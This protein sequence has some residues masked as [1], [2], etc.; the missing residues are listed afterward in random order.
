[1]RYLSSCTKDNCPAALFCLTTVE[2]CSLSTNK[3]AHHS[4][5]TSVNLLL[6]MNFFFFFFKDQYSIKTKKVIEKKQQTTKKKEYR[7]FFAKS[8]SS[9]LVYHF[10]HAVPESS[11]PFSIKFWKNKLILIIPSSTGLSSAGWGSVAASIKQEGKNKN[12]L[13]LKNKFSLKL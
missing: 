7:I 8:H 6:F 11:N 5:K 2:A 10:T 12:R 9:F 1:M 13:T 4:H 3:P